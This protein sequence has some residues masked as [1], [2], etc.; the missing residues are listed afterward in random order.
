[1]YPLYSELHSWSVYSFT[2]DS[3]FY[4]FLNAQNIAVIWNNAY[5]S[6][7][8][9][10]AKDPAK[11]H[12][13][14]GDIEVEDA[15]IFMYFF[16][17]L[18]DKDAIHFPHIIVALLIDFL[19]W[20]DLYLPIHKILVDLKA[21]GLQPDD[22]RRLQSVWEEYDQNIPKKAKRIEKILISASR[23]ES[24]NNK[25][26]AAI[27]KSFLSDRTIKKL[28]PDFITQHSTLDSFWPFIRDNVKGYAARKQYIEEKLSALSTYQKPSNEA[29][30]TSIVI[31]EAYI[32]EVWAKAT[33]R[34]Q[35]DP[36]AAIT[37]ARS[38]LE[39]VCKH[40]L[41]TFMIAYEDTW[42]LPKLYKTAASQLNLSPDQHTKQI[43]KQILGSC[44]SVVDGLGSLRNKLG[45]AHGGSAKRVKP[46]QRHAFLAVNLAGTMCHFLMQSL[47]AQLSK[48]KD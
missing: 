9:D 37:S 15:D 20:T 17:A 23:Q 30:T 1:L 33:R 42:D 7:Y 38:L 4:R 40:I 47:Q 25:E 2:K 32:N 45:D 48:Q 36:E 14:T 39:A 22:E 43:F 44:Q 46:S 29:I 28:V 26:Y 24:A 6:A 11:K 21:L 41:E 27:R 10:A 19:H 34:L 13:L 3:D 16:N 5:T 31:D 18:Y 12:W 35:E 8:A